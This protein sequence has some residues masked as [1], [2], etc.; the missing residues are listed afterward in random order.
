MGYYVEDS[1]V[2]LWGYCISPPAT[3]EMSVVLKQYSF[4]TSSAKL[5]RRGLILGH[6]HNE[7][8]LHGLLLQG[9][10]SYQGWYDQAIFNCNDLIMLLNFFAG[11]HLRRE[12]KDF[13]E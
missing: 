4:T 7:L 8:H 3:F 6:S 11:V 9:L 10:G 1:V 13:L 2:I 5:L 12:Y